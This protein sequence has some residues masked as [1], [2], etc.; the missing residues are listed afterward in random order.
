MPPAADYN[1]P[2]WM[3]ELAQAHWQRGELDEWA[4]WWHRYSQ[5]RD[6]VAAE[7]RAERQRE[8]MEA[9]R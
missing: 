2:S 9:T 7:R 4:Q 6:R 1:D 5:A 8:R 3:R